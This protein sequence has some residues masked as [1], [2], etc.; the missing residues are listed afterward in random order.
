MYTS[1]L[2]TSS[3]LRAMIPA[4]ALLPATVIDCTCTFTSKLPVCDVYRKRKPSPVEV[5]PTPGPP[6]VTL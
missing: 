4:E 2:P 1:A 5:A 3:V 6:A